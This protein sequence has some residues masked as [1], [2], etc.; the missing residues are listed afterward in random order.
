[1]GDELQIVSRWIL[2]VRTD[3][4]SIIYLPFVET[5]KKQKIIK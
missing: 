3:M 1:M 5:V 4:Q 2:S